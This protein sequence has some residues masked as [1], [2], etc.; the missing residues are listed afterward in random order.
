MTYED[1]ATLRDGQYH[2]KLSVKIFSPQDGSVYREE[3]L[4]NIYVVQGGAR[5]RADQAFLSSMNVPVQ[6]VRRGSITTLPLIPR[7]NTLLRGLS[8]TSLY[9]VQ[10][11]RR[12]F[13][14]SAEALQEVGLMPQDLRVVP[15]GT[16]AQIPLGDP[17]P[18]PPRATPIYLRLFSATEMHRILSRF[19][20]IN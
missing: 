18:D 19:V 2:L 14:N 1:D 11:G 4:P 6:V 5:L 9:V 3:G 17:I 7:D 10:N 12:H 20:P 15:D 8:H 16:L 13:A